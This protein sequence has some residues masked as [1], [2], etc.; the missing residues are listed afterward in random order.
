MEAPTSFF[1]TILYNEGR[2]LKVRSEIRGEEI[3]GYSRI[4]PFK[5]TTGEAQRSQYS[6]QTKSST[7]T[8]TN[9][10]RIALL[11]IAAFLLA[12]AQILGGLYPL[13]LDLLRQH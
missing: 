11:S 8:Y 4:Y 10:L 6:H 7:T 9:I 12:R 3:C 5:R 1:L 13:L 2:A